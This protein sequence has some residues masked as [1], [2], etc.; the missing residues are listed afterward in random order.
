MATSYNSGV[1]RVIPIDEILRSGGAFYNEVTK[2]MPKYT[3]DVAKAEVLRKRHAVSASLMRLWETYKIFY[4]GMGVS[5]FLYK[6]V[7]ESTESIQERRKRSYYLNYVEQVV[8]I[9]SGFLYRQPITRKLEVESDADIEELFDMVMYDIDRAKTS[10]DDFFKEVCIWNL[11]YGTQFIL[12]D[13]P[14]EVPDD[15]KSQK[16][17]RAIPFCIRLCPER[18]INWALDDKNEFLWVRVQEPDEPVTDPFSS[19]IIA[20]TSEVEIYTT[21]TR[22][23]WIRHKITT[24]SKL[25]NTYDVEVEE[26][27]RGVHDLGVVPIVAVKSREYSKSCVLGL[28]FVHDI[29]FTAMT[30]LNVSSLMDE[31]LYQKTMTI[32]VAKRSAQDEPTIELGS[33]NFLEYTGDTAPD[34]ISPSL[35]PGDFFLKTIEA[36]SKEIFRM[37]KLSGGVAVLE[38]AMSGIAH[39]YLFNETNQSLADQ[40]DVLEKAEKRVF[41]IMATWMDVYDDTNIS[42]KYP[43]DFGIINVS[44]ELEVLKELKSTIPSEKLYTALASDVAQVLLQGKSEQDNLKEIMDEI[45]KG[46]Q[47]DFANRKEMMVQQLSQNN[48][49]EGNPPVNKGKGRFSKSG[50]DDSNKSNN[51]KPIPPKKKKVEEKK[52]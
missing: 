43:D 4:E 11:V 28:S 52:K 27:G 47:E 30:I 29:V 38:E 36:L 19:E 21:W 22:K 37:A 34:F 50:S 41:E 9:Y 7:R 31:E 24:K 45:E 39:A 23:E 40:A 46:I 51:K 48:Q 32:L 5:E 42:I 20:P 1:G 13:M 17:Q 49:E 3:G 35:E 44:D 14:Q 10:V 26:V 2:D 12:V 33:S 8:N 18:V 6:H 15:L 16:E 25:K